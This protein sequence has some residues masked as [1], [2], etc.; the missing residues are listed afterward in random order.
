[1][2]RAREMRRQARQTWRRCELGGLVLGR[3][4]LSALRCTTGK[5][6][7]LTAHIFWLNS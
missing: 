6:L 7:E 1:M 3:V 4:K 2:W 5:M